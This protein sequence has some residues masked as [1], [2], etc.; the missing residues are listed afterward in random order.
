MVCEDNVERQ[1]PARA[2]PGRAAVRHRAQP[3]GQQ[4]RRGPVQRRV[5]R[6]HLQPGR[7]HPLR[8]HPGQPG[9]DLRDLGAVALDRGV[10]RP[11][12]GSPVPAVGCGGVD[13]RAVVPA[14][15]AARGQSGAAGGPGRG[16][17]GRRRAA[18]L[19]ARRRAAP[20]ERRAPARVPLPLPA[21]VG[22]RVGR[23]A[24]G[25]PGPAGE[26]R[27]P[28]GPGGRGR[29]GAR[30]R[31]LRPVRAGAGR[32][33][34]RRAARRGRA[35][36]DRLAVR[37]RAGPGAQGRRHPV[38][39]VHAVLPVLAAARLAGAGRL[40]R[41][42]G[43]LADR[44]ARHRRAEGP[45]PAGG[46]AAAGRRR[47][48]GAGAVGRVPRLGAAWVCRRPRPPGP[49]RHQPAVGAPEVRHRAP[50]DAAGRPRRRARRGDLP[51]RAGLAGVLRGR[52]LAPARVGARLPQPAVPH[53]GGRHRRGRGS[54][55]GRRGAPATRSWTPACGSCG[56]RRGCTTGS[57]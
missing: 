28:A 13:E 31:R 50:A 7:A 15:P 44:G 33:G 27:P 8:Q 53:A 20:A 43:D 54:G 18:G 1:L 52:A 25:A 39:G 24:R 35:G 36:P 17:S 23:P 56:P 42:G 47:G 22:R 14:R 40:G 51:Q 55:P 38:P 37:G 6:V 49:A 45:G 41:G 11:T 19:R 21:G 16:R 10:A 46:A 9:H 12:C 3:A 5:R 32:A 2:D 34:G 30:R 57:G 48:R 4:H 26:R 29:L